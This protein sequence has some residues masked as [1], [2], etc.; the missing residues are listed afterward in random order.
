MFIAIKID[1]DL[2]ALIIIILWLDLHSLNKTRQLNI[3]IDL[4]G[5]KI[6]WIL[7]QC[8]KYFLYIFCIPESNGPL[9][10]VC[11]KDRANDMYWGKL[12][13]IGNNNFGYCNFQEVHFTPLNDLEKQLIRVDK[14]NLWHFVYNCVFKLKLDLVYHQYNDFKPPLEKELFSSSKPS[15]ILYGG[16]FAALS[17]NE[18]NNIHHF[19]FRGEGPSTNRRCKWVRPS[20]KSWRIATTPYRMY[21]HLRY[22]KRDKG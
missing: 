9:S 4:Y 15:S 3:V 13:W 7:Y 17:T 22:N 19:I 18:G 20:Q 5:F 12:H 1:F 2:L 10:F 14:E 16:P 8:S 6:N 11:I 21:H